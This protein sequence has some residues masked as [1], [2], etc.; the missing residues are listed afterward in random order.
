MN[1]YNYFFD[2][3]RYD[4]LKNHVPDLVYEKFRWELV[5]LGITDMYRVILEEGLTREAVESDYKKYMPKEVLKRHPFFMKRPIQKTLVK[6]QKT[7][8]DKWWG[9]YVLRLL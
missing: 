1:A 9:V 7:G 8:Y 4:V 5:G 6:L 2:Q 3:A